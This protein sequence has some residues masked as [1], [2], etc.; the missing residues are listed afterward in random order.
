[1]NKITPN[2]TLKEA[3]VNPM[4]K[5]VIEKLFLVLRLP[6][7]LINSGIMGKLKFKTLTTAT[8][9]LLDKKTVQMVCDMLNLEKDEVITD[10]GEMTEKWW[11]EA[12]VYQ[13]YPR[14]FYD[15]NGDGIGDLNGIRQKL[16][17]LQDL[18]VNTIWCSPFYDSPNDDNGY[19]I[20]DYQK[21]MAEF[22]TMEDFDKLLEE[23]HA[24]DMKLVIDLVV[25][26]TSD[27]H[28]WFKEALKSKDNPYHDY[29]IWRDATDAGIT[30]PNNWISLFKGSGWNYY[31]NLNQWELHLFT[32]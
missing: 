23:I 17:Y 8:A 7:D 28:K 22:G 11:K 25:N 29:Y 24:R 20:R 19:D 9:G 2:T 4:A 15:S 26:H 21:I 5:D 1:M 3:M 6:T 30:P 10:Q 18:G 14:S 12:I 32:K 13:I 27:E 16:D 31:E